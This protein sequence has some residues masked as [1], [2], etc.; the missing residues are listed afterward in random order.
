VLAICFAIFLTVK[1]SHRNHS[2]VPIS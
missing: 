1:Q 2:R